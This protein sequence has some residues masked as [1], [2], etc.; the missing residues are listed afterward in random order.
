M[1]ILGIDIGGSALKGAPVDIE[2]GAL[3]TERFRIEVPKRPKPDQVLDCAVELVEHFQWTGPI[4][5]T[6]PAIVKNGVTLSAAN[7]DKEWIGYK[8]QK[9]LERKTHLPVLLINDADAAGIAEMEFGAGQGELG[10]VV[11]LTLGTGIGSAV[12]VQG[13]LLPNTE[14]GHIKLRGKDAEARASARVKTERKLSWRQWAARLNEY[15][16]YLDLLISPDLYI[17]GGGV[18]KRHDKFVP[19]LK[20]TARI[21]PAKLFNDAGI[22]GAAF[23]A[24][25]LAE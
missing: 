11:M 24:R 17:I 8:T 1:Q 21:V 5:C 9:M 19:L 14:F 4:G 13:R 15:L 25:T 18:S 12:F 16:A 10:T 3:V 7:V 6:F 22:V 23:A 20:S 2:S